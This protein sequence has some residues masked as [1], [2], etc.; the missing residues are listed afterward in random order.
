MA[1]K[2]R[3]FIT[4]L[5]GTKLLDEERAFLREEVE[6]VERIAADTERDFWL[7]TQEALDYGLLSR[8]IRTV[9]DLA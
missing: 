6:P 9:D 8:V 1:T 4:G 2:R 7:N 5:S 3:A